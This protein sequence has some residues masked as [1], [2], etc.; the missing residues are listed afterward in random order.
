MSQLGS[1]SICSFSFK[2]NGN[3]ESFTCVFEEV[4]D[5]LFTN[6]SE[7]SRNLSCFAYAFTRTIMEAISDGTEFDRDLKLTIKGERNE[8]SIDISVFCGDPV[9]KLGSENRKVSLYYPILNEVRK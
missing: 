2:T 8:M 6:Q 4:C 3:P 9:P 7:R 1:D 5:I